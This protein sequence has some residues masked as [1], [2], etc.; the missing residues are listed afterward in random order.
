MADG[1]D[2]R[3]SGDAVLLAVED[4][5]ATITLNRTERRNAVDYEGWKLLRS[6]ARAV[7][8]RDDVRVVVITGAGDAAFSA[9]ADISDLNSLLLRGRGFAGS[10][11][12]AARRRSHGAAGLPLL[13]AVEDGAALVVQPA[14]PCQ[15]DLH[16]GVVALD[17]HP[18]RHERQA[19]L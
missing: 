15:A 12:S 14:P 13:V 19:L 17:V 7:S 1:S 11:R 4:G 8:E 2:G 9:G 6:T 18:Q 16:L 10:L 5:I 3:G